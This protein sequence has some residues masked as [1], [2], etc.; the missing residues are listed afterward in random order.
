MSCD[1]CIV[2]DTPQSIMDEGNDYYP[3]E[4]DIFETIFDMLST[5]FVNASAMQEA[6]WAKYRFYM[7]GSCCTDKWVRIMADR[8]EQIGE[9]WDDIMTAAS[10]DDLSAL[11]ELSYLRLIKREPITGT[12]G[13]VRTT[14]YKHESLP[15]TAAT[16]TE[17]L[18]ERSNTTDGY[19]PNTQDTETYDEERDLNAT[20]FSKMMRDYPR[21]L[22]AFADEFNDYF[23]QRWY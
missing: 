13:D 6:L 20:T 22:E 11:N 3:A 14:S 16:T 21:I 1:R 2:I 15:Q 18:D 19:K 23:V 8:L 7:L 10:Q 5:T 4:T 17:Y 9:R 12:D